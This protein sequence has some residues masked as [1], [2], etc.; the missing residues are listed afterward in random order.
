MLTILARFASLVI[1]DLNA[2][3]DKDFLAFLDAMGISLLAPQAA[4]APLIFSLASGAPTDVTLPADTEVAA[5]LPPPLPSSLGNQQASAPASTAPLIFATDE[6]ISLTRA[7]LAAVHSRIPALDSYADHTRALTSSFTLFDQAALQPIAHHLY[8]GHDSLF[9]LPA[10]PAATVTIEVTPANVTPAGAPVQ[11]VPSRWEYLSK[12]GWLAF[13]P[14]VDATGGFTTQASVA[15]TKSCGPALEKAS[16]NGVQSF[17]LRAVASQPLPLPGGSGKGP[18]LPL[19]SQLRALVSYTSDPLPL[20]T[21]SNNGFRLDT[22][23]HFYPFGTQP[24]LSSTFL[25]ACDEAF[26]RT[27]STIQVNV[28]LSHN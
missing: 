11:G 28:A 8:L 6:A 17:W 7:R 10:S 12:E 14:V 24:L 13:E 26:K 19:L 15:L 4:R 9:D 22:S 20:D 3:P 18:A 21:A 27:G 2:A 16:V 25:F 1:Q 23:K 5:N